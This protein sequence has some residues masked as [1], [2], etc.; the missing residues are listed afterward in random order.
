MLNVL[1]KRSMLLSGFRRGFWLVK[2]HGYDHRWPAGINGEHDHVFQRV[3]GVR[4][5]PVPSLKLGAGTPL[6]AFVAGVG[7][8][9]VVIG[10][11][12]ACLAHAREEPHLG[13]RL[14]LLA[15]RVF[16]QF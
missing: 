2:I 4:I 11:Y 10:G 3:L 7:V 13:G 14:L 9:R 5:A 8:G 1:Y 6:S 12:G 16:G 15:N